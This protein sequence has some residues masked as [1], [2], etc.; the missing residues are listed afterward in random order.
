[1]KKRIKSDKGFISAD[2]NRPKGK[3]KGTVVFLPGYLDSKDYYGFLE[4]SKHLSEDGFVTVR[5]DPT[6]TW[7]SSGTI[8]DYSISQYLSDIRT[9]LSFEK[10]R[11]KKLKNIILV[12]HSIGGLVGIVYA[13]QNKEVSLLIAIQPAKFKRWVGAGSM[14]SKR[15]LPNNKGKKKNIEVPHSFAE[16]SQKY[17][18]LN[19][20]PRV[21]AP[22]F[23]IA[24]ELDE[25]ISPEVV[26]E[27][28]EKANK[29]KQFEIIKGLSHDFRRSSKETKMLS[30]RIKSIVREVFG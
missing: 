7:K 15:D 9:V 24:G 1:M 22:I 14:I 29:P 21:T 18:A 5:F 6:G 23:F 30:K 25:V 19:F 12:G 20:V 26:K 16:D 4:F 17:D 3:L 2:I 10:A 27:I 8:T 11:Q 28:Y 13:S